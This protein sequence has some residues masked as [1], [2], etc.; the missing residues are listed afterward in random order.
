M[1][2]ISFKVASTLAL[3]RLNNT[4][5]RQGHRRSIDWNWS[6]GVREVLAE[7]LNYT[8]FS[9]VMI[10]VR[11][12]GV[13]PKGTV[14]H[15]CRVIISLSAQPTPIEVFLDVSDADYNALPS[16][17]FVRL[18]L[19]LGPLAP[20]KSDPITGGLTESEWRTALECQSLLEEFYAFDE[21][22]GSNLG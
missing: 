14:H 10:E 15:R 20:A 19:S 3:L 8:G 17:D 12:H 13:D 9:P 22:D 11:A 21:A 7:R 6:D 18:M 16:A 4:A 1:N 2:Q 5:I